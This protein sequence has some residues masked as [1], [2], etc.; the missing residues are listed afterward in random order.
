MAVNLIVKYT[1]VVQSGEAAVMLEF[2]DREKAEIVFEMAIASGLWRS[3]AMTGVYEK[4]H[5]LKEWS[6][7]DG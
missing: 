2:D 4:H 6:V 3:V 7:E 1:V 5:L